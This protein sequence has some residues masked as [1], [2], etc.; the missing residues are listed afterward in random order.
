MLYTVL[1]A[2]NMSDTV[3][4][5]SPYPIARI[6]QICPNDRT[7]EFAG[8]PK[9]AIEDA[10]SSPHFADHEEGIPQVETTPQQYV[11]LTGFFSAPDITTLTARGAVAAG[12]GGT[13]TYANFIIT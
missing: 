5:V 3:G 12:L 7:V 13:L 11:D 9:M 2:R 10:L 4:V 8:L 6:I 1:I